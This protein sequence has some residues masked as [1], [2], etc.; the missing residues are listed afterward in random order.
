M[1]LNDYLAILK[2]LSS[3]RE[4]EVFKNDENIIT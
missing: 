2:N 4:T 1:V 3:L